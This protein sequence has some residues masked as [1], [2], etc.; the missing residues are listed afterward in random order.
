MDT[1]KIKKMML[2]L[3]AVIAPR[4]MAGIVVVFM[5]EAPNDLCTGSDLSTSS[6]CSEKVKGE[7]TNPS[8]QDSIPAKITS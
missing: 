7:N 4:L 5:V 1:P 2:S 6:F 3:T 8:G